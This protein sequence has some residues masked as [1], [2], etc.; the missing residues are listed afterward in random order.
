MHSTI[1]PEIMWGLGLG[2]ETAA[3]LEKAAGPGF[4][5]R[6][7]PPEA[8]GWLQGDEENPRAVWI[9]WRVWQSLP[10]ARKHECRQN[11]GLRRVLLLEQGDP[12]LEVEQVLAMGFTTALRAPV[13]RFS[14][15]ETLLR[16]RE[17]GAIAADLRRKTDEVALERELIVRKTNHLGLLNRILSRATASLDTATILSKARTDLASLLPITT[18]SAVFWTREP[19][20]A[21]LTAELYTHCNAAPPANEAWVETLL[22]AA[23]TLGGVPVAEFRQHCIAP[24]RHLRNTPPPSAG[25]LLM[26]PLSAG[27]ESFGC[28]ALSTA[29]SLRLAKDQV[30]TLNA[31]VNHLALALRNALLFRQVKSLAD[32]DALTRV[33]NRRSFDERLE[34]ERARHQRYGHPL[35]LL[36]FDVDHFKRVNDTC[37]HQAGDGVLREMAALLVESLRTTDFPA[38]YGGEEFAVILPHTSRE[39]AALLAERI[40]EQVAARTFLAGQV[41]PLHGAGTCGGAVPDGLKLT[42]SAGVSALAPGLSSSDLVALADQAL[43]LAKD[44]GRNRVMVAGSGLGLGMDSGAERMERERSDEAGRALMEPEAGAEL[45]DAVAALA[46]REKPGLRSAAG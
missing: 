42:V 24:T 45:A 30:Q 19:D 8:T 36:L 15:R 12:E 31:A 3:E 5:L 2:P 23:R 35:A 9:P 43:Y 28:L 18:L 10:K 4:L 22:D 16:L 11:S 7:I 32:R 20:S 37:G 39:Q 6:N 27:G 41:L 44:G 40:R 21:G 17:Q 13:G 38:R 1:E 26:L 14:V 29:E 33:A 25:R 34:G 46:A